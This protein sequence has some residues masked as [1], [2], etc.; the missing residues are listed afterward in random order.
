MIELVLLSFQVGLYVSQALAIM[1]LRN[2][3]ANKLIPSGD[4]AQFLARMMGFC[5]GLKFMSRNWFEQLVKSGVM[6]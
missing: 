1:D 3:H 5:E 2:E 6:M 4:R